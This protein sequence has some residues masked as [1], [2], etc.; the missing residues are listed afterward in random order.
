[1]PDTEAEK[2]TG[3]NDCYKCKYKD[4]CELFKEWQRVGALF[5]KLG[6]K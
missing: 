3:L 5:C 4:T 2:Q 1:M 6:V